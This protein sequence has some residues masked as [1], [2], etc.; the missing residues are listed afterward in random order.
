MLDLTGVI[1]VRQ[2][3]L[4]KE[5]TVL[6]IILSLLLSACRPSGNVLPDG[7][8]DGILGIGSSDT[9]ESESETVDVE[10]QKTENAE[11][12]PLIQ[13]AI[14]AKLRQGPQWKYINDRVAFLGKNATEIISGS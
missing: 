7:E 11:T 5:Y 9:T 10:P 2:F 12:S 13:N 4:R 14:S 3:E 6:L 1:S 8:H